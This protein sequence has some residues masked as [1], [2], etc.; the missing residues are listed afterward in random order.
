MKPLADK[1]R[2]QELNHIFGQE[3]IIGKN[4]L[5]NR[6]IT[7]NSIPNMIFYGPS[8]TG[9]TTVANIIANSSNKKFYKI[10][11]TNTNIDDI[12]NVI[13]QIGTLH[14]LN[15]ILLYIDEIHYLTKRQQQSILEYIE[16]GDITL[17]GSTTEN[18]N[19]SIF[20]ALLSR[21]TTIEFKALT[22]DNIVKGLK[23]SILL[24]EEALSF[25]INYESKALKY[26]AEVSGGDLRRA[27]NTLE[28][29][30]NTYII[31]DDNNLFI[32][33]TKAIECSQ[34][35]ITSYDRDGDNHYNLLSYFQKSIRGSDPQASIH[36]LA[37]LIKGG[38]LNSICRRLLVISSEDIGLAYP[39]AIS[40]VKACTDS[41][42]Q[43]GFPEARIPLAQATL[44][45]ASLPK[46]NSA[47]KAIN[48]A[49]NDLDTM[50]VGQ[51]PIHLCDNHSNTKIKNKKSYLY[52]H[53]YPN[54]Y[55]KQNYM[56]D[57]IKHKIYY[58]YG[59]N[60][61]EQSL[62]IYWDKIKTSKKSTKNR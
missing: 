9:K 2:P 62:E 51:I 46:S 26:I 48:L 14:T 42:L 20:N 17:I 10:N 31:Y 58:E 4:K 23:R 45:L 29:I 32:D 27:L 61:F 39:Q 41:A 1:I 34:S 3:H 28:L 52:P 37:R 6:I 33:I 18:V 21:C 40:I 8:G 38:D 43:I 11:G 5:L 30:I 16:N 7:S 57:P 55:V 44:L 12:K 50:D 24:E 53:A 35:K 13:S 56:P 19:F 25:K 22:V 60:K 59:K 36:A 47:Y 49:L 54:H 15:G